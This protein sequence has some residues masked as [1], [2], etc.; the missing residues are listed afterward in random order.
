M[1]VHVLWPKPFHSDYSICVV[2][3]GFMG[4]GA[5]L[6]DKETD[7]PCGL[8]I[9]K[10]NGIPCEKRLASEDET[11]AD[12]RY[13]LE[14]CRQVSHNSSCTQCCKHTLCI[15]AMARLGIVVGCFVLQLEQDNLVNSSVLDEV[16]F[17][18][19]ALYHGM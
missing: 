15:H 3:A 9:E 7:M 18:R 4:T 17:M 12:V 19:L 1:N 14:M 8:I 16:S 13:L 6:L 10:V 5:C 11:F 2:V